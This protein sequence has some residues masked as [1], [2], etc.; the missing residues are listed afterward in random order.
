MVSIQDYRRFLAGH[1]KSQITKIKAAGKDMASVTAAVREQMASV[2]EPS[3]IILTIEAR[4]ADGLLYDD[5]KNLLAAVTQSAHNPT[6]IWG[7][8]SNPD[9]DQNFNVA[10]YAARKPVESFINRICAESC[11]A[12]TPIVETNLRKVYQWLDS[13]DFAICPAVE[14]MQMMRRI[15]I[16]NSFGITELH[17]QV[18]GGDTNRHSLLVVNLL[19]VKHFYAR[20][21]CISRYCGCDYFLCKYA[22]IDVIKRTDIR[23]GNVSDFGMIDTLPLRI[24]KFNLAAKTHRKDAVGN[25]EIELRSIDDSEIED[26]LVVDSYK[27]HGCI[28]MM[29]LQG[30]RD[31]Y[32]K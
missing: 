21:G 18:E 2:R 32:K 9:A 5:M 3:D 23:N 19:G 30:F 26:L 31:I 29:G 10:I 11:I 8:A 25:F 12:R 7:T 24:N 14:D 27:S 22:N 6:V 28:T 17:G 20:V 1:S 16:A 15:F 13:H 4:N